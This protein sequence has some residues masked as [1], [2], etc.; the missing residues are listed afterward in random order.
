MN[1]EKLTKV[2]KVCGNEYPIEYFNKS[3]IGNGHVSV[4]KNCDKRNNRSGVPGLNAKSTENSPLKNF[5]PRQLMDELHARGYRGTLTLYV[6]HDIL[7]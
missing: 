1:D 2:C 6:K 4:C 3:S 5:T 7:V